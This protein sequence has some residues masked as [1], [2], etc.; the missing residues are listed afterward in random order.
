MERGDIAVFDRPSRACIFEGVLANPPS[1]V[2]KL[3][4]KL[5]RESDLSLSRWTAN[6]I[7]LKSLI[8]TT[9]RLNAHTMV[10]TLM[11]AAFEEPIYQW[12]L[13]KGVATTVQGYT[14]IEEF[15]E[16]LKYNRG[17][18][19]VY[20]SDQEHYAALGLRAMC[21]SPTTVWSV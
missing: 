8:D 21:V 7:Q 14:S 20:V 18:H 4:G 10:F 15:R 3:V 9:N 2:S 5:S 17:L 16:D 6:E 11:G 13:R 19:T 1:T 12:L